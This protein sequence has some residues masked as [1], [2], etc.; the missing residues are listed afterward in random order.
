MVEACRTAYGRVDVLFNNVGL[1]LTRGPLETTEEDF[2]RLMAVN[3]KGMFL[4]VKAVLPLMLEQGGGAI[5]NNASICAIRYQ[6]PSAI[7]SIPRPSVMQLTAERRRALRRERH[8]LQR[9]AAWQHPDRPADRE[10]QGGVRR[11]L[12]KT[13]STPAA[14]R[15]RAAG[16]ASHGTWRMPCC[17]S[18]PTR[19]AMSMRRNSSSTAGCPLRSSAAGCDGAGYCN[20]HTV[21]ARSGQGRQEHKS[22]PRVVLGGAKTVRWPRGPSGQH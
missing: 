7:Y 19:R 16:P 12:S 13:R 6:M 11:R 17:F 1:F 5:V 2:D 22:G 18:P 10:A 20:H 15:S 14:S 9:R 21:G 3:L 4:T 8:P